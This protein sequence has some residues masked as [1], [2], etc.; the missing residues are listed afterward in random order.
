MIGTRFFPGQGL[1]NQ[2]W[3]YAAARSIAE[4]HQTSFR[5]LDAHL[6]KGDS[7]L[8][9]KTMAG[10]LPEHAESAP[11]SMDG[12]RL[13]KEQLF[14]DHELK[15]FASAYDQR[16]ET[17]KGDTIIEGLFQSEKY[18]YSNLSRLREWVRLKDD[19]LI[20]SRKHSDQC[21]IN[22]RGGE[23]KR[24][25]SLIL[26]RS[27]WE[28]A[29]NNM[30]SRYGAQDFLIV[31]DDA[32]Y[33]S[34]LLPKIPILEG[35]IGDC[36]AALHGAGY[37]IVSNSSFS[38]FPIK[39]RN[40]KPP[41]IAPFLW[42]RPCNQQ[43]RWASPANL[44]EG[45]LWQSMDGELIDLQTC[46]NVADKTLAF[47]LNELNVCTTERIILK[48]TRL[49]KIIPTRLKLLIKKA[50]SKLFPMWIG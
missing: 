25:Q 30:K 9:I 5:V 4:Y 43:W 18:F 7:F 44:Y 16:V 3:V 31:T 32:N 42:S 41:V 23:Y 39:T 12:A 27:Y 38:Y 15:Y 28:H 26:P 8:D 2:L 36:Y 45:W 24:H 46:L 17:I 35:N 34:R 50:L 6:F 37:I 40:D 1:G 14:Y 49:Q 22:V 47:Y 19:Y 29:I 10:N 33:A 48:D 13:L 21:V 11:A 20:S